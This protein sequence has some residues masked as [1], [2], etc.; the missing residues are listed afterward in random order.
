MFVDDVYYVVKNWL[1]TKRVENKY[2]ADY[3][4]GWNDLLDTL[5]RTLRW[6]KLH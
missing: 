3:N 4:S 2:D 1:P 6:P 5:R